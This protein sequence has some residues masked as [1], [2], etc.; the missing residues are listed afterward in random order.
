[1]HPPASDV[2][3]LKLTTL[4]D[5]LGEG[6]A[7]TSVRRFFSDDPPE[8]EVDLTRMQPP[9]CYWRTFASGRERATLKAFFR[10]ADFEQY[11]DTLVEYYPEQVDQ[12]KHPRGGL[13]FL[14]ELNAVVWGFPFDPLMPSLHK[15]VDP[16]WVGGALKRSVEA[17]LVDYTPEIGAMVAYREPERRRVV[18]FGKASP[19]E[20]CGLIYLVMK[21]LWDSEARRAGRLKLAKPLAFRPEADLLL[22]SRVYG[23]P[24]AGDRNRTIFM[25]LAEEAGR[26]L[27]AVHGADVPFGSER[28]LDGLIGRLDDSLADLGL[29][30]PPL[31]D[32]V[33]RLVAQLKERAER[34]RPQS[35]V[36]SHGDYKYDQLLRYR[37]QFVLIDFE[38]YCRAEPALD[39]G[40]FCAYLPPSRPLGWQD[41]AAAEVLRARF[42]ARYER[43]SGHPIDYAR[44]GLY[45]AAMLGI[46]ANALV[47]RQRDDW[48]TRASQML[49][50][51]L[52]RLVAPEPNA[53]RLAAV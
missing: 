27:A 43:A 32:T 40:T 48:A 25:R 37:Q 24:I 17:E 52:E 41:A 38:L 49:D 51:A 34:S 12:P 4:L 16:E 5:A 31:Y 21:R 29:I 45:E 11:R 8:L 46:R 15:C 18:A 2:P 1:V 28:K 39:L 36:P 26:A 42:L 50:L 7:D 35:P 23:R 3:D 19:K 33:K 13:L 6:A 47:T 20:T 14:D 9:V 22:Q 30:A 53:E 10:R 44:L